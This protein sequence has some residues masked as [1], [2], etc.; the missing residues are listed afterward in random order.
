M[1]EKERERETGKGRQAKGERG[2]KRER[3]GEGEREARRCD[4]PRELYFPSVV[5]YTF[6]YR[7]GDSSRGIAEIELPSPIDT[8]SRGIA[9][10]ESG[11]YFTVVSSN[12]PRC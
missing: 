11:F 5:D 1:R 9:D 12:D 2:R 4:S 7:R 8:C 10:F 3:E 6:G